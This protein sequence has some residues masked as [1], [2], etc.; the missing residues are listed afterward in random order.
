MLR[1]KHYFEILLDGS[2]VFEKKQNISH[3]NKIV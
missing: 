1:W 3:I 2:T